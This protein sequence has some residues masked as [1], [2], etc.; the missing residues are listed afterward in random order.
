MR[1]EFN[2]VYYWPTRGHFIVT[3]KQDNGLRYC[4]K[5]E[6]GTEETITHVEFHLE[7]QY[8]PSKEPRSAV[9]LGEIDLR[10]MIFRPYLG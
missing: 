2:K 4:I 1:A 9:V 7:A 10:E 8:R 3:G 6:D 5:W